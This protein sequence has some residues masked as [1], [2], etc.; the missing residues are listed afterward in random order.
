MTGFTIT[1]ID[2]PQKYTCI[3]YGILN[4][5]GICVRTENSYEAAEAA[6]AR[7]L[8]TGDFNKPFDP[9]QA[10]LMLAA[11]AAGVEDDYKNGWTK[12]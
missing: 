5:H 10:E 9:A 3:K 6:I 1:K 12:D 8:E 2:N 11:F 4:Q 7:K